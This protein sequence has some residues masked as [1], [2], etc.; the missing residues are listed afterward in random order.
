MKNKT[1][2]LKYTVTKN[3]TIDGVYADQTTQKRGSVNWNIGHQKIS[4]LHKKQ[5]QKKQ[6]KK[7]WL[8]H[9]R[10]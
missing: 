10:A 5:K 1:L 3:N 6:Q 8:L 7:L 9:K 2:E 4:R